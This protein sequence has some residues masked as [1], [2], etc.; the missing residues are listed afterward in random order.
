MTA[1]APTSPAR[2]RVRLAPAVRKRLILDA[3]LAEFSTQGFGATSTERIA[4]RA[5]LSQAGLYAH[6]DSKDAIFLALLQEMMVPEWDLL[7]HEDYPVTDTAIDA[8]IDLSYAKL[9]DPVFQSVFRILIAEGHRIRHLIG[10]W[11][12]DVVAPQRADQQRIMDALIVQGNVPR[13]AMTEH[14]ELTSSP[15]VHALMVY[16]M[17]GGGDGPAT[18][19]VAIREAHRRLLKEQLVVDRD[20]AQRRAVQ[21]GRG[22]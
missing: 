1:P 6:F 13:C 16:M 12:R 5:G 8:W 4:Q 19:V 21:S 17:H 9:A 7:V 15:L 2:K 11:R 20:G 18:E 10:G 3:A 14:T 22:G